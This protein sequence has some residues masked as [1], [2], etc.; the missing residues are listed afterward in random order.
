MPAWR[1]ADPELDEDLLH[2]AGQDAELLVQ[3]DPDLRS[4]RG[5]AMRVLLHLFEKRAAVRT[6]RSG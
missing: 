2:M 3:K 1:L 4:E 5:K 6:L